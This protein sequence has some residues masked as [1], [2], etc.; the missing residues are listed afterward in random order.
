MDFRFADV[1]EMDLTPPVQCEDSPGSSGRNHDASAPVGITDMR[2]LE[3]EM[4]Q[5]GACVSGLHTSRKGERAMGCDPRKMED[6]VPESPSWQKGWESSV[7]CQ[8]SQT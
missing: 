1:T 7:S 4:L 8:E 2:K 3:N 5:N 6:I